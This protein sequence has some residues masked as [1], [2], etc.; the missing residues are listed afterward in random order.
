MGAIIK[1]NKT[2]KRGGALTRH[3]PV[4]GVPP[5]GFY[6]AL[7]VVLGIQGE[8]LFIFRDLGRR[9]IHFQGFGEKA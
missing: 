2:Q 7:P 5:P 9:V 8:G 1:A 4:L 3:T 6:E